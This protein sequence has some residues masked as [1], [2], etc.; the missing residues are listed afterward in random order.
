MG[1]RCL[2]LKTKSIPIESKPHLNYLSNNIQHARGMASYMAA[3]GTC[4]LYLPRLFLQ[5][6]PLK[7]HC[8]LLFRVRG[9]R[10]RF[11][12]VFPCPAVARRALASMEEAEGQGCGEEKA[13]FS[14][15][16]TFSRW[17]DRTLVR[18]RVRAPEAREAEA[19]ERESEMMDAPTAGERANETATKN[20]RWVR[21]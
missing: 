8:V 17:I 7:R 16:R 6:L 4:A 18:R 9:N 13:A 5:L 1:S 15:R 12:Y 2:I 3:I 20:C 11:V 14:L 10:R 19:R 21:R